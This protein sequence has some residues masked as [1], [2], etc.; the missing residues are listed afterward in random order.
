MAYLAEERTNSEETDEAV[1]ARSLEEPSQFAVLVRK[2]E[3]PFVRKAMGIIN[4]EEEAADIVQETFTKIYL[5]APKFR[6]VEG[7]SFSSWAY[8]ILINTALTKYARARRQGRVRVDLDPEIMELI[9]D[10]NLR[11]FEKLTLED[12]IASILSRIPAPLARALSRFFIEGKTQ[13]EM[14]RE[15]GV[16]VGAIKSRVHRAKKEFRRVYEKL[17]KTINQPISL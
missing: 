15:E 5:N 6:V 2:Y 7:A 4:D 17:D 13:E 3:A 10:R 16:S 11:Q 1:L 8:R 12:E 14:A 9:P